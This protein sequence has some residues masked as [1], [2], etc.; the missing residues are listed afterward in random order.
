MLSLDVY[1]P[2]ELFLVL[3]LSSYGLFSEFQIFSD[4]AVV[5]HK[6]C[7]CLHL[8]LARRMQNINCTTD[9]DERVRLIWKTRVP[10]CIS[11]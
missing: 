10:G 7:A 3:Q 9:S 5:D 11:M 2:R 1:C 4:L 8:N 6:L